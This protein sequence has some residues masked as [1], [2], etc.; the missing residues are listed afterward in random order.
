LRPDTAATARER[1]QAVLAEF[2]STSWDHR[3]LNDVVTF[4]PTAELLAEHLHGHLVGRVDPDDAAALAGV[5]VWESQ[6]RW[7]EYG[8]GQP[9]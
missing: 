8:P 1:L 7:A 4:A 2:V 6:R 3:L 9:R 5:R